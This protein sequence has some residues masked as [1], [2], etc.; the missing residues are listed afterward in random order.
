[1]SFG[2]SSPPPR[3]SAR[4][5]SL[6]HALDDSGGVRLDKVALGTV[7]ASVYGDQTDDVLNTPKG[8]DA[9]SRLQRDIDGAE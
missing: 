3:R 5:S 9:L 1:M 7:L 4:R 6:T 2:N 8:E